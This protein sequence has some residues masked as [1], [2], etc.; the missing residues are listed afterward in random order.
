ML[1]IV[2]HHF[3]MFDSHDFAQAPSRPIHRTGAMAVLLPWTQGT[4]AL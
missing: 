2:N 4:P 1:T 3:D